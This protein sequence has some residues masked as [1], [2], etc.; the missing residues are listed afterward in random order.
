[1]EPRY[2]IGQNVIVSQSKTQLP[3]AR[4]S[5]IGQYAGQSGTVTDYYW[6]R[7]NRGEVFYIYTVRMGTGQKEIVLHEDEMKADRVEVH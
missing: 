6:I 3:S 4:D 7:P 1:M 2:Q 5:D